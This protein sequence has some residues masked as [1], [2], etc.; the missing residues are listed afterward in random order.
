MAPSFCDR[1]RADRIEAF[2][3]PLPA[4]DIAGMFWLRRAGVPVVATEAEYRD[5]LHRRPIGEGAGTFLQTASVAC[6]GMGRALAPADMVRDTPIRPSLDVSSTAAALRRRPI[7]RRRERRSRMSS[8]TLSTI[9][10][11]TV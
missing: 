9:S 1:L 7:S 5:E 2:Q 8:G 4:A 6:G 11:S 3:P 10:L